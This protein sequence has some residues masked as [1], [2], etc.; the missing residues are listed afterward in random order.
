M[1]EKAAGKGEGLKEEQGAPVGCREL[2][3]GSGK[4]SKQE[5]QWVSVTS[6]TLDRNLNTNPRNAS[7]R[8]S[9]L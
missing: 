3:E 8:G 9:R 7:G 1:V 4:E 2:A 5:E 6:H